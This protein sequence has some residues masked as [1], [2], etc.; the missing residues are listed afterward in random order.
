VGASI[1]QREEARGMTDHGAELFLVG[2]HE[3][4][5]PLSFEIVSQNGLADTFSAKAGASC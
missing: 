1:G 5:A 2:I 3:Q 4:R